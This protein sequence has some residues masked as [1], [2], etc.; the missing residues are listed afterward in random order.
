MHSEITHIAP[1][2]RALLD[3]VSLEL[4]TDTLHSNN[5]KFTADDKLKNFNKLYDTLT[6]SRALTMPSVDL[7][8]AFIRRYEVHAML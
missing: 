4:T 5:R 8:G 3:P 7:C 1:G 6:R 2:D